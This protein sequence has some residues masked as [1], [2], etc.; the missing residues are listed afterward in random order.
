MNSNLDLSMTEQHIMTFKPNNLSNEKEVTFQDIGLSTQNTF[1]KQLTVINE[2]I[3]TDSKI[4]RLQPG[5][6]ELPHVPSA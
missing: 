4:K 1:G 2:E 6:R 3:S 5:Y